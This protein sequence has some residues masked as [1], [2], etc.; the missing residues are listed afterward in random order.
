MPLCTFKILN[1]MSL[2]ALSAAFI[3][4]STFAHAQGR[5]GSND[6]ECMLVSEKIIN[7]E[8]PAYGGSMKWKRTIAQAE[9]QLGHDRLIRIFDDKKRFLVIGEHKSPDTGATGIQIITMDFNGQILETVQKDLSTLGRIIDVIH[10]DER[11]YVLLEKL[12]TGSDERHAQLNVYSEDGKILQSKTYKDDRHVVIPAAMVIDDR[13]DLYIATQYKRKGGDPA[14]NIY[15]SS[16]LYKLKPNKEI[17]WKR[18]LLPSTASKI[19]KII[20]R[21]GGGFIVAGEVA[22]TGGRNRNRVG[23]WLMALSAQGGMEWQRAY[24]RGYNARLNYVEENDKG[25][26]FAAGT[27][28]PVGQ[29]AGA[30]WVMTNYA[31]SNPIWQSFFRG[32]YDYKTLGF[33]VNENSQAS[34]V[35]QGEPVDMGGLP[36]VRVLDLSQLGYVQSDHSYI[37]GNG[38]LGSAYHSFSDNNLGRYI[39][40]SAQMPSSGENNHIL[41]GWIASLNPFRKRD[42]CQ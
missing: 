35:L 41:D 42:K 6:K 9:T 3:M 39:M 16:V 8:T 13:G 40:G 2:L 22:V 20:T 19:H 36:H 34:V 1:N 12:S 18:S 25:I 32:P 21:K 31:N 23:G 37:E 27:A 17:E 29:E 7:L 11:L 15:A 33:S 24:P 5:S 10:H 38:V 28:Y 26:I 30:A 14:K 4:T